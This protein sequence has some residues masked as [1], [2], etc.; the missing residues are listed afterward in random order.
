MKINKILSAALCLTFA[1]TLLGGL[2]AVLA[3]GPGQYSDIPLVDFT[4]KK[5]TATVGAQ[6]GFAV[7]E[8]LL[9]NPQFEGMTELRSTGG[10][11]DYT[12]LGE[13]VTQ[14]VAEC[15]IGPEYTAPGVGGS[16]IKVTTPGQTMNQSVY[17][18]V[19]VE[20]GKDY[21]FSC[22]MKLDAGDMGKYSCRFG[23]YDTP[24]TQVANGTPMC[25][26]P[27]ATYDGGLTSDWKQYQF[28]IPVPADTAS[29]I[30][31][32]RSIY[33][34][35]GPAATIE[36]SGYELYEFSSSG[37]AAAPEAAANNGGIT[38]TVDGN[39]LDCAQPPVIVD[40]RTL[41]P[42]RAIFE[43]LGMTVVWDDNLRKATGTKDGKEIELV[44]GDD[45]AYVDGLPVS[46]DVPAQIING[47]TLVPARFV[48]EAA[49][50]GVDWDAAA[51]TVM[52]TTK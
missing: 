9:Q 40:G 43:A 6:S 19:T 46:L 42:V 21:Y 1:V 51:Q 18:R 45:A 48:A 22:W 31:E 11:K 24:Q 14:A 49:G 13:W 50:C 25:L 16:G 34:D 29:T 44:I 3:A 47:S 10:T 35:G 26:L 28:I 4:Q 52:I 17:Q 36:A 5:A 15:L 20:P 38:V 32:V 39:V 12:T 41:V 33:S 27:L 30:L 7:G 37:E 8:N 2:P 23:M